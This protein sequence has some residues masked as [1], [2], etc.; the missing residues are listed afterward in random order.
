MYNTYLELD[1]WGRIRIAIIDAAGGKCACCRN[2]A[3]EVHHR[4]YRPRIMSGAHTSLLVALCK[5][6]H[7]KV[8]QAK[9]GAKGNANAKE[10]MLADMFEQETARLERRFRSR[11]G[12]KKG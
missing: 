12:A 2:K 6:C 11:R 9:K 5:F 3:T 10:A 7:F 1:A 8:E 4:C